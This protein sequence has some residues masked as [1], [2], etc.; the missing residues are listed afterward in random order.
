MPD[1]R[2]H[3]EDIHQKSLVFYLP[4]LAGGGAER[5]NL[6]M[7]PLFL[8]AGYD[9]TFLLQTADGEL[10]NDIPAGVKVVSLNVHRTIWALIPLI[11]F[12][13]QTRPD[14]LCSSLG[15]NNIIAVWAVAAAGTRTPLIAIQHN[16]LSSETVKGHEIKFAVLPL[17]Y[18]L[19]LQQASG[20][21]AVSK[22][23]ANDMATVARIPRD[24]ID[25]IYNPVVSDAFNDL[26][27]RPICHGWLNDEVPVII[28]VGRLVEQKDFT[29]LLDAFAL[30]VRKKDSR[31]IIL[32]DGPLHQDLKTQAA[33]L[34][35]A[36]RVDLVGFQTNPLPF[37]RKASVLVLSSRYEGF[38]SVLAEA[39][40]CGTPVVSTDCPYGPA[41]IL[42]NGMYGI[43]VPVGDRRAMA[44]AILS[45]L[46][47]P[48]DKEK[49]CQRGQEFN[50]ERA[51]NAYQSLFTKV[52]ST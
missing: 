21:V 3:Q 46:E 32:G 26:A 43:L 33:Q 45:T 12:L 36:D 7:A 20:I 41:E 29:T 16:A 44:D 17:L 34:G 38:G 47:K 15:H 19:F 13:R 1:I 39:M 27:N 42:E 24:K 52:V 4:N 31:L 40:A 14:I 22:G 18:R 9:V 10:F 5:L 37:I 50:V 48:P 23:V 28:G 30:V 51:F 25:V 49:L 8:N 11:K 6:L 35:I 2:P